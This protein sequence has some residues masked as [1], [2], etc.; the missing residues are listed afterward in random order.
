MLRR[1]LLIARKETWHILRDFRTVYMALGIPLVLL[2]LFG[3]ALTM[4]VEDIRLIV[5]DGDRTRASRDLVSAFERSRVFSVVARP[6][7][8]RGLLGA[9]RRFEAKAALIIAPGFSRDLERGG[10]GRAQ[11]IADGTD[12][13]VAAIAMGYGAAI[14]QMRTLDLA[15]SALERQGVSSGRKMRPPI[16]VKSRN[17]FNPAL[18]SQWFMVPG[19]IALLMAMMAAIL[20]SLTVAREWERGTMEQLLITPVRPIEIVFGK[21]LPYF[22]IGIGQLCLVSSAGVLLF[23]VPFKGDIGLLFGLSCLFLVGALSQGL[24]ISILTR[25]QQL[26]IQFSFL[27]SLLPALLLSGFMSP[28]ASMPEIIQYITY[29]VPARYFLVILRGLFLK[30]A[31]FAV[32]RPEVIALSI[33]AVVMLVLASVRFKARLD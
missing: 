32:L 2:L 10:T 3:Y 33:Y 22:C 12:A 18:K 20:M 16:E 6:D 14:A 25:Q 26:A 5:V 29:I 19:L 27:T 21:L 15:I 8:A 24:L 23:D 7:H 17:W 31:A 13:N 4:D 9:F 30:G 1:I 28:I 11:L